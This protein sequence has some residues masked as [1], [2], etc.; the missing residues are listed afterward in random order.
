MAKPKLNLE[1][2]RS[3]GSSQAH[4]WLQSYPKGVD[5]AMRFEPFLISGLLDAAIEDHGSRPCTYFMGRRLS[6]AEIGRLS[7]QVAK[8]LQ[9]LGVNEGVIVGLLLPNSPTFVIFYLGI[10]KAGGTVVNFNPLYSVEEIEFQAKDSGTR[11]MVTL[12]LAATFDKV[13]PLLARGVL[14]KAVV[15][16]FA[17]LLPSLKSFAVKLGRGP[18]LAKIAASP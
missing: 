3:G 16:R 15:A 14:D 12:D 2:Q 9:E 13:E 1:N 8:G 4:L 11:I 18:K 10:L 17:S 6:Y 7:D 5:W